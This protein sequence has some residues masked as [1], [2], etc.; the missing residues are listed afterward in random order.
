MNSTSIQ[1][2]T[3]QRNKLS[4]TSCWGL[5]YHSLAYGSRYSVRFHFR[6]S[7][8]IGFAEHLQ[9]ESWQTWRNRLT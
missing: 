2:P 8:Q 6:R 9:V 3:L 7:D 1:M 4:V 5:A